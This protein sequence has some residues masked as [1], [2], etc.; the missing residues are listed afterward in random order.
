MAIFTE[1]LILVDL[2]I[3]LGGCFYF[4]RATPKA[5]VR[6]KARGGIGA[7]AAG[8]H[9]SSWQRRILNPLSKGRERT[10]NLMVPS[11]IH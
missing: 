1:V 8:L 6:S 4:F 3:L 11:R 9:H 5:Y 10:R 7:T 2:H